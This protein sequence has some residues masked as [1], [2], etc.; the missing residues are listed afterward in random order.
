MKQRKEIM[1]ECP[2]EF[3]DTLKEYIDE[4]EHE[5]NSVLENLE[6]KDLDDL[7]KISDARSIAV[8]LSEDIY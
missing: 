4:I 3:Q 7:H 8:S 6:V 2:E 1:S 5:V